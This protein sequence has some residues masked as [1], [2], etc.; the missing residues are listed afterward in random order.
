MATERPL[1]LELPAELRLLV[2]KALLGDS[3]D[4]YLQYLVCDGQPRLLHEIF[5][6]QL[7]DLHGGRTTMGPM[8]LS[9][10][11][12]PITSPPIMSRTTLPLPGLC[13]NHGG[14]M[15]SLGILRTC[16][17]LEREVNSLLYPRRT[18]VFDGHLPLCGFGRS[19]SVSQRSL[20][21]NLHLRLNDRCFFNIEKHELG[22]MFSTITML[23][24][25]QNLHLDVEVMPT[26]RIWRC[27]PSLATGLYTMIKLTSA[28]IK[29]SLCV[30]SVAKPHWQI[31]DWSADQQGQFANTLW[32]AFMVV[33]PKKVIRKKS[34]PVHM[35]K[36]SLWTSL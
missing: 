36:Y 2:W 26:N 23:E 5:W 32:W 35:S 30:A 34:V 20:L 1:L 33:L 25:L 22:M 16:R 27:N 8:N 10:D 14:P 31:R 3:A 28:T 29:V 19:L 17:E 7:P 9:G 13:E 15:L 18:F 4:I 24:G 21:Q 12:P 6:G 11:P